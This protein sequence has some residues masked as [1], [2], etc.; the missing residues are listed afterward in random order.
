MRRPVAA[1]YGTVLWAKMRGW[2]YWPSVVMRP[3]KRDST[4]PSAHTTTDAV[5]DSNCAPVDAGCRTPLFWS[6]TTTVDTAA[7]PNTGASSS[8]L[9]HLLRVVKSAAPASMRTHAQDASESS[10]APG[11]QPVQSQPYD[12]SSVAH[13]YCE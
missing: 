2:P 13:A 10:S 8:I 5:S 7:G 11:T 4:V 1:A 6:S 3:A 12:A 9:I